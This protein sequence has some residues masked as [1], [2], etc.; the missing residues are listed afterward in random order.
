MLASAISQSKSAVQLRLF[1]PRKK[2]LASAF[3]NRVW[4]SSGVYP[5]RIL[6]RMAPF[7]A[8]DKTLHFGSDVQVA[9]YI[10]WMAL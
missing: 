4:K 10:A 6:A 7:R 5:T 8:F 1:A 9:L 3:V 2:A